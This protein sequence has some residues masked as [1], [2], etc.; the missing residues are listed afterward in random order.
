LDLLRDWT[1]RVVSVTQRTDVSETMG[2]M[3]AALL[4]GLAEIEWE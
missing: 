1:L 2:R 4:L 3:V